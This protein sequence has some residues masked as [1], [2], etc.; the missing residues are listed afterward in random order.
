VSVFKHIGADGLHSIHALFADVSPQRFAGAVVE[1]PVLAFLQLSS[2][3]ITLVA[4]VLVFRLRASV[5]TTLAVT[6]TLGVATFIL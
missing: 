6:G 3:L 4:A 1:V 2:L 5:L